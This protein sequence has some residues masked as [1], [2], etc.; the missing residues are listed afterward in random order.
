MLIARQVGDM[1]HDLLEGCDHGVIS[2]APQLI[3]SISVN[4][5]RPAGPMR[6]EAEVHK[7]AHIVYQVPCSMDILGFSHNRS[8]EMKFGD[9]HCEGG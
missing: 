4:S 6:R 5:G 9:G 2:K 7:A 1:P 8:V 3:G